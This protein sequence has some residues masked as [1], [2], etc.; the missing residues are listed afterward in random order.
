MINNLKNKWEKHFPLGGR[1]QGSLG[2]AN[3]WGRCE[4]WG[5][6]NTIPIAQ[7][8]SKFPL[9]DASTWPPFIIQEVEKK[10]Q[11][12]SVNPIISWT[13][14]KVD[15]GGFSILPHH[16]KRQVQFFVGEEP[17]C[18]FNVKLLVEIMSFWQS[19]RHSREIHACL[20][21]KRTIKLCSSIH[22]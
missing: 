22:K 5:S 4:L 13:R 15:K 17:S 14:F 6:S 16:M 10:H 20:M 9:Q 3:R 8:F 7:P 12:P 21:W 2:N 19:H 18:A 11:D 1:R